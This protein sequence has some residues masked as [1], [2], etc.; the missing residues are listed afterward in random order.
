MALTNKMAR[1]HRPLNAAN[2]N[3]SVNSFN[4]WLYVFNTA[5]T[6]DRRGFS[7]N[8]TWSEENA[9]PVWSCNKQGTATTDGKRSISL[10]NATV[11]AVVSN[12]SIGLLN[13]VV[14][15]GFSMISCKEPGALQAINKSGYSSNAGQARSVAL[16]LPSSSSSSLLSVPLSVPSS[17]SLVA[18]GRVVFLM[19]Q[20]HSASLVTILMA[21]WYRCKATK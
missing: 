14:N 3:A 17:S 7:T 6:K 15:R 4:V 10:V 11:V 21:S 12:V 1:S 9:V 2:S 16:P 18:A 8:C 20:Q 5:L 13:G 19:F